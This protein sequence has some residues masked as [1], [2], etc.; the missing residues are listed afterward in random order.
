MATRTFNVLESADATY[1]TITN[2]GA[3]VA[4]ELTLTVIDNSTS[5]SYTFTIA[6]GT[7]LDD[8]NGAGLIIGVDDLVP[9]YGSSAFTDGNYTF[10]INDG[11]DDST[12][13]EGFAAIQTQSVMKEAL[14]YNVYLSQAAKTYI[15]EKILYLNNLAYA[16]SVGSTDKFTENLNVLERMR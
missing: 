14:G 7:D 8:F 9:S 11:V 13:T 5:D 4:V 16:A 15:Q 12:I 1:F 6:A 10:T 2:T 3:D